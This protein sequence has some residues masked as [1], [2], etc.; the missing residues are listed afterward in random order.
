MNCK[1]CGVELPKGRRKYCSKECKDKRGK[2]YSY[3]LQCSECGQMFSSRYKESVHCPN[4]LYVTTSRKMK[5]SN[6]M[7]REEVIQKVS[8]TLREKYKNGQLS[9]KKGPD[10]SG[11]KG[12]RS[13]DQ[14]CRKRLYNTWIFPILERDRFKC[15]SCN[16]EKRLQV[17]HLR[18]M[19]EIISLV[20]KRLSI[21]DIS[22]LSPIEQEP[23]ID[24]VI[25]EHKLDD[26]ITVCYLC[27]GK[28]DERYRRYKS[29]NQKDYNG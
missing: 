23:L 6:P 18:P 15:I 21:Q 29:E 1:V 13:F 11:W 9:C 27:H 25:A 4:C 10:R 26:G 19:R 22:K 12:N 28:I 8:E 14:R 20:L 2:F 17:H 3:Q 16:S 5:I 24:L 7:F